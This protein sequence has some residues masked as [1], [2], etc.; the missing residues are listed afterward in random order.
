M[1]AGKEKEADREPRSI[2]CCADPIA[3]SIENYIGRARDRDKHEVR[4]DGAVYVRVLTKR[5][6]EERVMEEVVLDERHDLTVLLAGS[7]Y[8]NVK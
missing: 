8:D 6:K 5:F 7:M 2:V 4:L 3:S 1:E